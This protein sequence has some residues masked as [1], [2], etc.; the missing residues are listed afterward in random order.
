MS[1]FIVSTA[2][3]A[4]VIC[5]AAAALGCV[6]AL[7]AAAT[8]RGFARAPRRQD[9]VCPAVSILKP[10]H[11][12]E[13][14]LYA[15]LAGFCVQDYPGPVQ[16]VFGVADPDDPA[17]AVVRK[18]MADFACCDLALV[19]D[20]RRHGENHKVSNLIN[21]M[22]Q[23]RHDVLVASDSDIVVER[24][25]LQCVT[26]SLNHPGV[27]MVTCLYRGLAANGLWPRLAAAQIDYHFLPS[28]LIGLRLGLATPAFGSTIAL[29]RTTLARIG[30]F[31]AVAD[32]LADDYALGALVRRA[33]LTVAIP[34]RLVGHFC[35]ERSL[36]ELL[37]HELR[38]A[39]T[40]R[41]V[42]PAGYAGLAITHATPFALL[43]LIF[44]GLTPAALIVPLA[45]GCRFLL[46]A[47]IDRTFGLRNR[48]F[49][50]GPLR[51]ILSFV[52]FVMS[53]F[54]HYVRWRGRRY[55]VR[56]DKN[57][58]YSGEVET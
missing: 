40:I 15:H 57:L 4:S 25:Y 10:L 48:M 26:A 51:D 12:M 21:I 18:L 6:Y 9:A 56:A 32:R 30:G 39:R 3:W 14:D 31:E 11:G 29:Q 38:W 19:V 36:S 2:A 33:G 34:N 17:I 42:D 5:Y 23:A 24:D 1:A 54:G 20:S 47:R 58:A 13:P 37:H 22:A 52:V 50:L 46:Q 16:I 45:I 7:F 43:G 55:G 44:G 27:G 53:F 8:V 41:A 49:W 35:A 28:V